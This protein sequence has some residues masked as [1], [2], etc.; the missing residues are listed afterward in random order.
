MPTFTC[1]RCKH[2]QDT[3]WLEECPSCGGFYRPI[4]KGLDADPDDLDG[5]ATMGSSKRS[6]KRVYLSTG[7]ES[8]DTVL[9]GGFVAGRV[10][11]LGGFPG[12]GKCLGRGT[13]VMCYD[14]TVVPVEEVRTGDLLMGPDSA[15]RRVLSTVK[16][17][18]PLYKI[19]PNKGETWVCNDV[20]VLT[21]VNSR[22]DE[23]FDIPLDEYLRSSSSYKPG[24]KLFQPARID[25]PAATEATE[26][27]ITPYFL[28]VW[29]GD[30]AKS[31]MRLK[32]G[33]QLKTVAITK[34]D[35]EI[36]A[37]CRDEAT[38]Y[39]LRVHLLAEGTSS[40]TYCISGVPGKENPLLE[41]LRRLMRD[42]IRVPKSYLLASAEVRAEVLAGL[43]DTDGYLSSGGYEIAQKSD[44]I[45][46]DVMF[47]ARSLGLRATSSI[48]MVNG[49]PYHR[50]FIS[51]ETST[52][53]L[54]IARKK[55]GERKQIKNALRTGFKVE[56]LGEGEFF[57]FEL[58]GDGRFL[59]GDFTVTHNTRMLLLTADYIGKTQG[60]VI[61][62]SGEESRDQLEQTAAELGLV[63]DR[64]IL[65][66][67]QRSVEKVIEVAEKVK[68]FL[69]IYD[70]AQKLAS[71]YCA[72]S[73]G[74]VAQLK[75]VGEIVAHRCRKT[76]TCAVI[77]NQMDKSGDLKGGTEL[78]HH[79]D[80][81]MVL[82][83]P[84]DTDDTAP[85]VKD[86][87]LLEGSKNRCGPENLKSYIRMT[88]EGR[89][90]SIPARSKLIF[91]A[92]EDEDDEPE[93]RRNKYSRS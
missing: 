4:Q 73:I 59:L 12:T 43:L 50:M 16:G 65:M 57:G 45:A 49:S 66:G 20:H 56:A 67:N 38:K 55:A 41:D 58:D 21:L 85:L 39:G 40:I 5:F 19:I 52:L 29:L 53:P 11:L 10:V 13:P 26:R 47:L 69:V 79:C 27:P 92:D 93:P 78:E 30:G 3:K 51:G 91:S 9:G 81:I 54:R 34:P 83:Y 17:V 2:T 31:M 82:A 77:V 36:E 62:A 35:A 42:E 63:N 68:A 46:A 28:G 1:R 8:F 15:P 61:Y 72:G 37:A 7:M 60:T 87:R 32:N 48:K 23:V 89:P 84:K 22:N 64:V 6:S 88:E 18:G 76:K 74:S 33:D 25:F 86:V 44:A 14:G 75:A 71:D 90:E 80:T 24:W 70:S